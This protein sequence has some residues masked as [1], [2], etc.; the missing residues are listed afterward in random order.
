MRPKEST[1]AKLTD[2]QIRGLA[3]LLGFMGALKGLTKFELPAAFLAAL[4]EQCG[5][6]IPDHVWKIGCTRTLKDS[7]TSL[8]QRI[9]EATRE[10]GEDPTKSGFGT[11]TLTAGATQ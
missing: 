6:E 5:G 9:A 11:V 8:R 10:L 2:Y 1:L 7:M 3:G 4:D